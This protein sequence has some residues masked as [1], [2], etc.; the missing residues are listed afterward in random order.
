M[1]RVNMWI[2]FDLLHAPNEVG[3]RLVDIKIVIIASL[4]TQT[5]D[6]TCHKQTIIEG[7]MCMF[8]FSLDVNQHQNFFS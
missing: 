8:F 4:T 6:G 3:A 2:H 1:A 7:R 5:D